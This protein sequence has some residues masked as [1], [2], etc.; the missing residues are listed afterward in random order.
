MGSQ[1]LKFT[2]LKK[3]FYPDEGYTKR[4]VL[5]YYDGVADLILPHLKDRPLSLKRYP[6]GIKQD[7][8]FQKDAADTFAPWL[9]TELIRRYPLRVRG[10][11]RQPALPGEPGL[12]RPQSLD[13]PHA[14][15]R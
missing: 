6:N 10:G 5:N 15:A 3:V 4:D 2:N 13:E 7:Y 1:T 9:R 14:D 12:H 8:F 11:S